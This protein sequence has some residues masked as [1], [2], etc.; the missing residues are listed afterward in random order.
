M[1]ELGGVFGCCCCVD[2]C[3]TNLVQGS[4]RVAMAV[5]C[6]VQHATSCSTAQHLCVL[7]QNVITG[8]TH[9]PSIVLVAL[10]GQHCGNYGVIWLETV[11]KV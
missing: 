4:V 10:G 6:L 11:T 9:I 3:A 8:I 5:Q 7:Q 2:C 1:R